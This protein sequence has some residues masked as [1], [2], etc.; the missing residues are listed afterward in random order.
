MART[1]RPSPHGPSWWSWAVNSTLPAGRASS[2]RN[3]RRRLQSRRDAALHVSR[4]GAVKRIILHARR[5]ERADA[6][7]RGGR[8]TAGWAPE[9]PLSSTARTIGASGQSAA[10]RLT[11]NPSAVRISASRLAAAPA[12]RVGLGTS[13]RATA[14]SSQPLAVDGPGNLVTAAL[15][16]SVVVRRV[17][18]LLVVN[19]SPVSGDRLVVFVPDIPDLAV[20]FIRRNMS[21]PDSGAPYGVLRGHL[22]KQPSC[23]DDSGYIV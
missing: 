7:Y 6:R 9:R 4:T 18:F 14:V 10:C 20:R 15:Y 17:V 23:Q 12:L 8:R 11:E 13:T 2:V 5:H 21:K 16:S 3:T 19:D 1:W 22:H